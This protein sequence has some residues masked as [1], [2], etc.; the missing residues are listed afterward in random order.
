MKS[1]TKI[2]NE[3]SNVKIVEALK[4]AL[5]EEFNAWYGYIVVK[6]WLVGP[7]R[8]DIAE[9]Y[10]ETA[11]DEF[12]DHACWLMKRISQLNGD[13]ED[14][15]LTPESLSTA[16]HKYI[17]SSWKNGKV[18]VEESLKINIQNELGAIDTY[19][20]LVDMTEG[21]DPAS[22]SKLKE[23]LADEEEHLQELKDFLDDIESQ[24]S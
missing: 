12:E 5:K 3:A 22:N 2:I 20:E 16:K 18:D 1:M 13:I 9:F 14:I 11:K 6:E 17:M 4:N 23:I 10:E 15:A 21:V 19:K 8:S 7:S 24:K